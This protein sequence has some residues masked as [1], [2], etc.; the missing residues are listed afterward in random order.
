MHHYS[1]FAELVDPINMTYKKI[2]FNRLPQKLTSE[3]ISTLVEMAME[4]PNKNDD[5]EKISNILLE[6]NQLNLILDIVEKHKE[7]EREKKWN[8]LSIDFQNDEL[9]KRKESLTDKKFSGN[10]GEEETILNKN[11]KPKLP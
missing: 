9:T 4:F 1:D 8:S 2:D 11:R 3:I 10:M 7:E 5:W 6:R